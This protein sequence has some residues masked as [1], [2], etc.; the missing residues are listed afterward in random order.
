M[1][2]IFVYFTDNKLPFGLSIY[3]NCDTGQNSGFVL[4]SHF[5][6]L[7]YLLRFYLALNM[8]CFRKDQKVQLLKD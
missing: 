2:Q 6:E 8:Y 5:C 7:K 1:G 4:F 3:Y